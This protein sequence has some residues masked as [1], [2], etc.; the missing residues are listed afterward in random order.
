M[1]EIGNA[2]KLQFFSSF[3]IVLK[4]VSY[5][6]KLIFP[7]VLMDEYPAPR[8]QTTNKDTSREEKNKI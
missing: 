3:F 5:N 4:L 1:G 8:V 2:D 6:G 7:A